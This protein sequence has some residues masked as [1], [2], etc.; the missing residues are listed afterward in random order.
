MLELKNLVAH[1][2]TLISSRIWLKILIALILGVVAGIGITYLDGIISVGL[3]N[4]I[5]NWVGFPGRLFLA[6]IQMIVIPLV[7][8]SVVLGI[9]ASQSID[10]LKK[11]G[12]RITIY[13][14]ITTTV[15]VSIGFFVSNF[16]KPGHEIYL[17]MRNSGAVKPPPAET[18][19]AD[20]LPIEKI[21]KILVD[22]LPQNP[23][24]AMTEGEMLQVVLFAVIIGLSLLSIPKKHSEIIISLL[25][26]VQEICM[27]VVK[28]TMKIAPIAVFGL[29]A[30]ATSKAGI[31]AFIGLTGY[32]TSVILGLLGILI[33][34][35]LII[36]VFGRMNPFSFLKKIR[37]VQ[38][39]AFSTSSSA[40]VM[41]LTL[42]TAEKELKIDPSVSRFVVPLGTTINMDGT[43]LYQGVA[44]VFL[45]HTAG[46]DLDGGALILVVLTAIGASIGS[47]G[48]PGVGIVILA[49]L[50]AN[51]G[52]PTTGIALIL[53]VDR[54]LDMCRTV[55]NVTGDLTASVVMEKW[56]ERK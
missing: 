35:L 14:L 41:P 28:W 1:L 37:P 19:T 4:T 40:A 53:G 5:S 22:L 34:Y 38:M 24:V 9:G 43:A 56:L 48:T 29:L 44:T 21:P 8:A 23:L 54:I 49:G 45:A 20:V 36:S 15:A 7:F 47:P 18:L 6:L 3:I 31:T 12:L 11:M 2:N 16:I 10:Q 51:L 33:F 30:E 26:S 55:V 32:V 50:L 39:L 27:A 17:K 52:V 25:T 46:I 13:F 42:E